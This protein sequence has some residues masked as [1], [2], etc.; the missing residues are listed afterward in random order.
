MPSNL[1]IVKVTKP[2]EENKNFLHKNTNEPNEMEQSQ[3]QEEVTENFTEN[4]NL[5]ANEHAARRGRLNLKTVDHI[6]TYPIVQETEEIAKKIALTRIILAQTKPRIDKVVVSRPVQTVAPVVNFFDKMANSTLST[7]ERVIPSL[8][9]KTYKRLGEEIV[10][11]YTLSK[12]YGKQ[13]RDTTARNG[14]NYIYQPV[15][16]RLM[17]F[18]K[19]YNEKFIDTKGKPLIRGQLDPVLL[20]VNNTFEKVTVKYLPKGQKVPN[21]SFSCEFNRGLA[22]EYNFMTRAVSAVSHQ[23]VG[24]AKLPIA[25]GYH[26]NSVYNKNLDKQGDLKMKNVLRG[27]WDTITDLEREIWASVTD[28]SLFRFFGNNSEG[29]DL[30]HLVQ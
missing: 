2:Q 21:D 29:G 13:F 30:P 12:K 3:T 22:L 15:H 1:N 27:T 25:Y 8:K 16:G 20:P 18:R 9:T 24:I 19:Y 23:V 26:T 6:E 4:S 5:S 10:L 11:P 7:V 14:D 28:G 17:K